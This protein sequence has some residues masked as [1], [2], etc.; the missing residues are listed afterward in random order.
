V[1]AIAGRDDGARDK[2]ARA[3]DSRGV[4]VVIAR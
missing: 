4:E 2:H 3:F 1:A